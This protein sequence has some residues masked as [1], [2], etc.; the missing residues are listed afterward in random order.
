M[1]NYLVKD[2]NRKFL[3]R[4]KNSLIV[5]LLFFICSCKTK[6]DVRYTAKINGDFILE[7]GKLN[8]SF[9]NTLQ[10]PIWIT[11]KSED[12]DL[13]KQFDTITLQPLQDTI[14]SFASA[15]DKQPSMNFVIN[16][17]DFKRKIEEH[18]L[19]LPFKNEYTVMQGFNGD[20]SHNTIYSRYAIDFNFKKNDTVYSADDGFVVGIIENNTKF[21]NDRSF[22]PFSNYITTYNPDSGLFCEYV[23]LKKNGSLVKIGDRIKKGQ[24]LAQTG[25]SGFMDG[26]HL[27]LNCKIPSKKG[28]LSTPIQFENYDAS[29]L[30]KGD[31]VKP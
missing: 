22:T 18:N 24:A 12:K 25:M 27:H 7:N 19:V 3:Y 6:Q 30:K 17:G 4:L 26:E 31:N 1:L 20:F 28:L 2:N 5:L 16:Y 23:H 9:H 15:K 8:F 29:T 14:F 11:L 13:V 21:G 10:C